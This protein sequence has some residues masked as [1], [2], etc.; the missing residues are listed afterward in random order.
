MTT[1]SD[2][3]RRIMFCAPIIATLLMAVN[4]QAQPPSISEAQPPV[5]GEIVAAAWKIQEVIFGYRGYSTIYSC[6]GLSNKVRAILRSVG[7]RDTLTVRASGC[8]EGSGVARLQ[9]LFESP[10][11]ATAQNLRELTGSNAR[12]E[13]IARV[14][15]ERLPALTGIETIP[16]VWKTVAFARDRALD[17][18]PGDCEL[19]R[20]VR[21]EI[22]PMLSVRVLKE[23]L[24]C[25]IAFGNIARPQLTIAALVAVSD[26]DKQ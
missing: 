14:R 17:L 20:Q 10:V 15:G 5:A 25:S 18:A 7:A 13:L 19:V 4:V 12:K 9:I 24:N 1:G 23:R 16:A 21:R 6:A 26:P 22:L 3:Q 2:S 11:E 8:N